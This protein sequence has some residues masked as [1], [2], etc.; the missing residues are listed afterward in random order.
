MWNCVDDK[1]DNEEGRAPLEYL[2]RGPRASSYATGH[3]SPAH[4]RLIVEDT[5]GSLCMHFIQMLKM[6]LNCFFKFSSSTDNSKFEIEERLN[7]GSRLTIF[8]RYSV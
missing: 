4:Q 8:E 5:I 3:M 6:C 2:P 1:K 7:S